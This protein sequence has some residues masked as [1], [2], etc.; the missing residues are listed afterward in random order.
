MFRSNLQA[1]PRRLSQMARQREEEALA[2]RRAKRAKRNSRLFASHGS[3]AGH[4]SPEALAAG[5]PLTPMTDKEADLASLAS[6][7]SDDEEAEHDITAVELSG[8]G[9]APA[10]GLYAR[11]AV[12]PDGTPVY[13]KR[14]GG[15]TCVLSRVT[16][17]AT[18]SPARPA[19]TNGASPTQKRSPQKK[20][21]DR[22]FWACKFVADPRPSNPRPAEETL[23][24]N[25]RQGRRA[26]LPTE[27]NWVGTYIYPGL[28]I[29]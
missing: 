19:G 23:Y 21:A 6:L 13:V 26:R 14:G 27:G 4:Q 28:L 15:G 24:I 17:A 8:A 10:N 20:K 2:A 29:V 25:T 3:G 9:F 12:G 18:S 16:L 5:A 1:T 7:T 11:K 22:L